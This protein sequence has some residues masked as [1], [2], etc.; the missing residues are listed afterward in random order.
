MT[1]CPASFA[2]ELT[3]RVRANLSTLHRRIDAVRDETQTVRI[4]AVTKTFGPEFVRAAQAVGL[5]CVGENYVNELRD[6][7]VAFGDELCWHYLGAVQTNK[8]KLLAQCA[9][10]VSSISRERELV[11]L[12]RQDR[13][14]QVDIEVNFT[15]RSDR[16][17]CAPG[18]VEILCARARSLSMQLRGLMT[19]AP[20]A[21]DDARAAFVT[22]AAMGRD[23]GVSELSMGMSDDLEWAVAAGSTEV[24]VG[25]ALFGARSTPPVER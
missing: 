11:A 6:K 2:E 22:L 19:V 23:V 13:T 21:P 12:A 5:G 10:V 17:G 4:V 8:A 3:E 20:V 14:V 15:G 9:D 7:R 24:R 1:T 16:G 25:R 18:D